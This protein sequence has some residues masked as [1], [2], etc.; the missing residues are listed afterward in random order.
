MAGFAHTDKV[1][2]VLADLG[3]RGAY[4][5]VFNRTAVVLVCGHRLEIPLKIGMGQT[6]QDALDRVRT[7]VERVR[8]NAEERV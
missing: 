4:C 5:A 6:E 7:Q 1:K 2:A 8:R 3:I